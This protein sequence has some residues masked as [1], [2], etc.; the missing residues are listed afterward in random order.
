[1]LQV[2]WLWGMRDEYCA[3][4]QG[5][6]IWTIPLH[7]INFNILLGREVPIWYYSQVECTCEQLPMFLHQLSSHVT[8]H[9]HPR[10]TQIRVC[11]SRDPR[12]LA[13]QQR[14]PAARQTWWPA[15]TTTL[16]P[17]HTLVSLWLSLCEGRPLRFAALIDCFQYLACVANGKGLG[18]WDD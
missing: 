9:A 11:R 18:L 15:K 6:Q 14:L 10:S 8:T 13:R 5:E 1:M 4:D 3:S 2:I 16:T 7:K 12:S 17:T